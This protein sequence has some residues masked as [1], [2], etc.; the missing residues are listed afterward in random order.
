MNPVKLYKELPKT[1]CKKC[2][3]STCMAF[4]V[5]VSKGDEQLDTCPFL[6]KE[7]VKELSAVIKTVDWRENLIT[8][9]MEDVQKIHLTETG[10]QIGA[11]VKGENISLPLFGKNFLVTQKG[12]IIAEGLIKPWEKILILLYIKMQGSGE[13]SHKWVSFAELKGG[14]VKVE[15]IKKE[16]EKPLSRL[17]EKNAEAVIRIFNHLGKDVSLEHKSDRAWIFNFLPKIP[18]M[19][20]YWEAIEEF[21]P[22]VTILFDPSAVQFLD[23]ESLVFLAEGF[24]NAVEDML[25]DD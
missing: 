25:K 11:T 20:Q 17:M 6:D 19:I 9:L 4:A 14:F 13:V 5:A 10:P 23:I 2:Q 1:N 7:Q 22:S 3:Y 15:A 16:C 21:P 24:V 12:D 18:V 8:S